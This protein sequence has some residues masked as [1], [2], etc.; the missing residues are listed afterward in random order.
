MQ[1]NYY[2]TPDYEYVCKGKADKEQWQ[3][4]KSQRQ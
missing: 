2:D 4:K 3:R 1:Q